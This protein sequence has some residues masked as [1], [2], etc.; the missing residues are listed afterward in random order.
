MV[1]FITEEKL[2]LYPNLQESI[3]IASFPGSGNT[4]L[5]HLFQITTGVWTGSVYWDPELF[6]GGFLGEA[7]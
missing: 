5:R 2:H 7:L 3:A 6:N 4:W 1:D